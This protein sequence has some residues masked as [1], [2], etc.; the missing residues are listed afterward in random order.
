M[1]Q[2]IINIGT[3]AGAGDGEGL[4]DGGDK[5]NDNFTELYADIQV[6]KV[7]FFDYNDLATQTTPITITGGAG[8][9]PLTND[10]LGPFTLKTYAPTGITDIW[11]SGSGVFDFSQLSLGDMIDIRLDVS[12]ITSTAN[13][14]V[15]INLFLGSGGS[16]YEIAFIS[17]NNYK[18]AG[19]YDV[20][21]YNG[22]YIGNTDT[23]T[24]GGMFKMKADTTCTVKVNGWYCRIIR[25]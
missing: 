3:S 9:I 12:I 2:Q 15:D 1:A 4:R 5:I 13:T 7:G 21:R 11:N 24:S 10:E 25:R 20:I 16:A 8:Y 6:N 14:A 17:Q 18:T 23:L 19:T 22:M